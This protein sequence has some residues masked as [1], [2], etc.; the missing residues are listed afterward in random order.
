MRGEFRRWRRVLV[1]AVAGVLTMAGVAGANVALT[2][3]SSD[4]YTNASSQHATELEPDTFAHHG[5][6]VAA[7]QVGRFFNG[8]ASDI[9]VVRS[10]DGGATWGA[11]NFLHDTFNSGDTSSPYE[12]V[13]DP[14]VA[15]DARHGVWMISSIPLLPSINTPTVFVNRSTDD[16]LTWGPAISIPPP[17]SN[18]VDLDK[19]W[20]VCDNHTSSPF[21]GHCYTELDNFGDGDLELM[22]TSTDGG[23]TWSVPIRTD[24]NDKGLG[25]QPLV[26]PN[27]TVI[28]PF[29]SLNGKI[30]A[31]RSTD[32]GASWSRAV[33]VSAIRFH[34]VDGDLRT[35]PLPTAEIAG[36]GRVFVAWEDCR[37]RKKC[38]GNDIVL[39]SSTDGA[40]WSDA[41]RVPID[42][43]TSGA[44]HFVPGLAVD[45][46]SSGSATRLALTFYFYPDTTCTGGC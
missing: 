24:G 16:G 44:D 46:T 2:Q 30:S 1:L 20:T 38:T 41:A 12:R 26:Q 10:G 3:V 33:T 19:N 22:S 31:F 15:Y 45:P 6:V 43:V 42:D 11:P 4:P 5:T 21:F 17:V 29:E 18:S 37:F 28:V 23:L 40:T 39:S 13:S 35:S 34:S 14:S 8:G 27:G 32:G 36:D 25:G 7:F 9:G